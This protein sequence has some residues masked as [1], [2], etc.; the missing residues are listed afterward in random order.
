VNKGI[1]A[2]PDVDTGRRRK[3]GEATR[4]ARQR[5]DGYPETLP[6]TYPSGFAL[7]HARVIR[8]RAD[9]TAAEADTPTA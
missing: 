8:Y 4:W 2:D 6:S 7:R 3:G 1:L 5:Q 9:K